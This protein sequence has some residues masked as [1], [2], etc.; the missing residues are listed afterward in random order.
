VAGLLLKLRWAYPAAIVAFTLFVVY[1]LYRYS[2]THST[3][4]LALSALD[5]AVIALT[6]LEYRR[7]KVLHGFAK[8]AR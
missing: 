8:A 6:W 2:H 7:L 1:Q 4:L 5:A 3:A